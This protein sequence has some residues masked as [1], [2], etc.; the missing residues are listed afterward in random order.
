M[1]SGTARSST[2]SVSVSNARSHEGRARGPALPVF[3]ALLFLPA[4][5][6]RSAHATNKLREVMSGLAPHRRNSMTFKREIEIGGKTL[7][8]ET[9]AIAK[10][11]N[12]ACVIRYGDT[13]V[14]ATACYKEGNVL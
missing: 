10:Q 14:L 7:S 9:G 8:L 12:G 13:V 2:S 5:S 11:A 4:G 3:P 1:W 6:H